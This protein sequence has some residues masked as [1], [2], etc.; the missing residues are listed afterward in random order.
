MWGIIGGSGFEK[1]DG[2]ETVK[3][4]PTETPFGKTS[5]GFKK[6]KIDGVEAL[7]ISRHGEHHEHLPTEV[8][9]RAN[10]FAMKLHGA[11]AIASV[12]AVGSLRAELAPGDMVIPT[13]YVDRTKGIRKHTFCG[14]G[15]VGHMSLATPVCEAAA[16][17]VFEIT[18]SVGVKCH[19]GG[20]YICI[21]GPNF[22]TYAESMSYRDFN[23]DII[24]MSNFPEYGLAREAGLTYLP[25]SFVTDY[26]C[27]DRTRPHVTIEEVITT[28]RQNNAK[29]FK[30]LQKLVASGDKI[31]EGC[32]CHE[33]GLRNGLMM[34]KEAIPAKHKE[35]MQVLMS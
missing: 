18:K 8:N 35:W 12:S 19:L 11:R 16:K 15:I 30:V 6:V 28:M 26:D 27:W 14:D 7:F 32:E 2:F 9:Y 29:G 13:Q 5:S 3:V 34:P 24:G 1:F 4:L 23:C 10:I 22:S 21:E 33:Q 25:C 20:T 17:R 31:L